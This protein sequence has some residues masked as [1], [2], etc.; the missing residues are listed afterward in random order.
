MNEALAAQEKEPKK[1]F[2]DVYTKWCG[3]CKMLD[4]NTFSDKKVIEFVNKNYYAVK[5][6]AEGTEE[7]TFEDV[8]EQMPELDPV[9]PEP[10]SAAEVSDSAAEAT[11]I[12]FEYLEE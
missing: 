12:K 5:F 9:E 10:L 2:M 3:P 6:N 1:I 7:I 4:R 8:D 11:D